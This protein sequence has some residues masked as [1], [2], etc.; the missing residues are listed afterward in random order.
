MI[1]KYNEII[2]GKAIFE[3]SKHRQSVHCSFLAIGGVERTWE[4]TTS[5]LTLC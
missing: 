1:W 4:R 2:Y 5:R 3:M